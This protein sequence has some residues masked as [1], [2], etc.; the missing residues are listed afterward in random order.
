MTQTPNPFRRPIN[1]PKDATPGKNTSRRT[2]S[3][4]C[5]LFNGFT[6]VPCWLLAQ[7]QEIFLDLLLLVSPTHAHD[8]PSI[9]RLWE[10]WGWRFTSIGAG[11]FR[12]RWACEISLT[13]ITGAVETCRK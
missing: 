11:T 6:T 7:K 12:R 13:S 8:H 3:D 2:I 5:T 1:H 9:H 10:V 4:I